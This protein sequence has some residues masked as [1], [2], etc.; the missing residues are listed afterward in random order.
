MRRKNLIII[1]LSC[2]IIT[3]LLPV[4]AKKAENF[5]DILNAHRMIFS[6]PKDFI[7]AKVIENDDV[8]YQNAIKSKKNKLEIRY[9]VFSLKEQIKEYEEWK[10]SKEKNGVRTDPNNGH[11]LFTLAVVENIAGSE[12]PKGTKFPDESVKNEF[13]ANWGASF[14]VECKSGFGKGYKYAMIT[15]LHKDSVANAYITY[16]FDDY[17][18]VQAEIV[19][20]F[21]SMKFLDEYF[22]SRSILYSA[23]YNLSVLIK[24][25]ITPKEIETKI[26]YQDADNI[27]IDDYLKKIAQAYSFKLNK[28]NL[29][30]IKDVGKAVTQMNDGNVVIVIYGNQKVSHSAIIFGYKVV[31]ENLIFKVWDSTYKDEGSMNASDLKSSH[32]NLRADRAYYFTR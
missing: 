8:I 1:L 5:T 13:G 2:F 12:N 32:W 14:F 29:T 30:N 18:T 15:A 31:S 26:N 16:L 6:M 3:L 24:T 17:K 19:N 21:Y 25:K 4:S 10:N 28:L 27:T 7:Q 11:Q 22:N 23:A 9:S 20:V